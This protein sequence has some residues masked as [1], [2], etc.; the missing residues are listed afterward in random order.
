MVNGKWTPCKNNVYYKQRAQK[1]KKAE[2]KMAAMPLDAT[3][4]SIDSF[5]DWP[6]LRIMEFGVMTTVAHKNRRRKNNR[7]SQNKISNTYR[8]AMKLY[9]VQ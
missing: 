7:E 1:S 3:T 4:K 5:G 6:Q 2:N 8:L 9:N